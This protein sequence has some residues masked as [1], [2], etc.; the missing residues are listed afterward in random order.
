MSMDTLPPQTQM[1]MEG[2]PQEFEG[3]RHRINC[4]EVV[5]RNLPAFSAGTHYIAGRYEAS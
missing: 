5:I 4:R 2:C 3:L 1:F